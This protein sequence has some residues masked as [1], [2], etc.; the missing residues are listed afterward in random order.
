MR[1]G[2]PA[3]MWQVTREHQPLTM[4]GTM[5][6]SGGRWIFWNYDPDMPSFIF[7]RLVGRARVTHM[8]ASMSAAQA[9]DWKATNPTGWVPPYADAGRIAHQVASF[10][11][12]DGAGYDVELYA[13]APAALLAAAPGEPFRTGWFV[14][15]AQDDPA[16]DAP[17]PANVHEETRSQVAG[18]IDLHVTL[19][20]GG[21]DYALE[22]LS[23]DT[24]I[25]AGAGGRVAL[26]APAP[27]ALALSDLLATEP[28][29]A[30]PEDG[31][32]LHRSA[33]EYR[34]LRCLALP[35]EQRVG[36]V[37][38]V[39]GLEA[40]AQDSVVRY[41]VSIEAQELRGGN[42]VA[43]LLRAWGI[44]GDQRELAGRLTFERE[45]RLTGDRVVE[46]VELEIPP[47]GRE[48][49]DVTVQVE[50]LVGRGRTAHAS[51][52]LGAQECM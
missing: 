20:P 40:E 39:Y 52:R 43:R 21:Y 22:M 28:G 29:L 17:L 46:W 33:I 16:P 2:R 3:T 1:Y 48:A 35:G 49:V 4:S 38:E 32:A 34:P 44:G 25:M 26:P 13:L 41:R 8:S 42:L 31:A 10:R 45:V 7:E 18:T 47:A 37:F 51:R 23:A 19:P 36:L 9:E 11:S 12:A 14:A 27:G 24:S 15:P 6:S 5:R 50:D 30:G